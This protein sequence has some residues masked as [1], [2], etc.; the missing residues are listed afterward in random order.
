VP[1][2][3]GVN[4]FS[5]FKVVVSMSPQDSHLLYT[6]VFSSAIAL[7]PPQNN[8]SCLLQLVFCFFPFW[9]SGFTYRVPCCSPPF[10][11]LILLLVSLLFGIRRAC[12]F[13]GISSSEG[14]DSRERISLESVFNN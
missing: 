14:Q 6:P 9:I 11:S 7:T 2:G 1:G 3:L 12:A 10:A 5:S 13:V 4:K 8:I